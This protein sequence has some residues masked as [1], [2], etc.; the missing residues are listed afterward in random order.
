[1]VMESLD[2]RLYVVARENEESSEVHQLGSCSTTKV[3]KESIRHIPVSDIFVRLRWYI[4]TY[5]VPSIR[6]EKYINMCLK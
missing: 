6:Q 3:N 4:C 1:M 5:E 2:V